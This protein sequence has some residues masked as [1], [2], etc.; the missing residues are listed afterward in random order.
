MCL[1]ST[2][3][4]S[5]PITVWVGSAILVAFLSVLVMGVFPSK[6]QMPVDGKVSQDDRSPHNGL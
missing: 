5:L 3:M 1:T 2:Q 6:N 4:N